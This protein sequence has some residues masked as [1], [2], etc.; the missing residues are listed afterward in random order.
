MEELQASGIINARIIHFLKNPKLVTS[1][2]MNS[3]L[4]SSKLLKQFCHKTQR[5]Y[6]TK[7]K[8][9]NKLKQKHGLFEGNYLGACQ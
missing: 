9:F 8:S 5:N 7:M 3:V 4:L 2:P 6:N 1:L